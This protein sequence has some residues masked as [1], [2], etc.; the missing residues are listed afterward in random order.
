MGSR[1]CLNQ[2]SST[3]L[4]CHFPPTENL[5][6]SYLSSANPKSDF[7]G[8]IQFFPPCEQG[9]LMEEQFSSCGNERR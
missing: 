3:I 8:I 2:R 5:C 1:V 4:L 6:S 7:Q 9:S